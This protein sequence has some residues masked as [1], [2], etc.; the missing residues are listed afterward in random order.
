[1][2][3]R[4]S[5]DPNLYGCNILDWDGSREEVLLDAGGGSGNG[6]S[7]RNS[8]AS[9]SSITSSESNGNGT[10][11][12]NSKGKGKKGKNA[13]IVLPAERDLAQ[14]VRKY[15]VTETMTHATGKGCQE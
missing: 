6:G 4:G 1:M 13:P 11:G 10:K 5:W 14:L 9:S 12:K 7:G 8:S 3:R 15:H 2:S